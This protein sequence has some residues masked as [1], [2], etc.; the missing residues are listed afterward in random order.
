MSDSKI[1]D[2]IEKSYN[3]QKEQFEYYKAHV[4]KV[5]A[6]N[7]SNQAFQKRLDRRQKVLLPVLF[8]FMLIMMFFLFTD[9]FASV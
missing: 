7:E 9:F 4:E 2:V 8:V 6:L 1:L 3:L 5:D